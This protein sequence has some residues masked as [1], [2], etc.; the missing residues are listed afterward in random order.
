MLLFLSLTLVLVQLGRILHG[1]E[2]R[3]FVKRP[4]TPALDLRFPHAHKFPPLHYVF[5]SLCLHNSLT[6][7]STESD[8]LPP[9]CRSRFWLAV[10]G[11]AKKNPPS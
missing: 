7:L 11:E 1:E 8:A 4:K 3:A 2:A 5:P 10:K 6:C 9:E